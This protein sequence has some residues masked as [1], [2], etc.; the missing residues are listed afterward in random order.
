[1][2]DHYTIPRSLCYSLAMREE[3][4]EDD[5]DLTITSDEDRLIL[6]VRE[7]MSDQFTLTLP[8]EAMT[9]II[10]KAEEVRSYG[11]VSTRKPPQ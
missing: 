3:Y 1:M 11:T 8:Q 2:I 9:E 6:V 7:G 4:L 10:E 5:D